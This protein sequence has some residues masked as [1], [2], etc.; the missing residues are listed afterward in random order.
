MQPPAI[1]HQTW[2]ERALA[3]GASG[4]GAI[5]Q[6]IDSWKNAVTGMGTR[7]DKTTASQLFPDRVLSPMELE[8]LFHN[9]DIAARIVSAVVNEAFREPWQIVSKTSDED[10]AEIQR[11]Q[12]TDLAADFKAHGVAKKM[13]EAA[14]W[15]RLYGLGACLIGV[16]EEPRWNPRTGRMEAIP[17]WEP[18]DWQRVRALDYVTVLDRRDMIPWRW[19]TDFQ[20][21][22]F[23]DVALYQ[24]QPAGVFMG[25]SYG[26]S[27]NEMSLVHESRLIRFGG[28]LTSKRERLRNQGADFSILQKVFRA[29][30]L[31]NTNWQA[32]SALMADASQGVF[33]ITGLVD[34]IAQQPDEMKARMEFVDFMRSTMQAIVLDKDGEDFTR[35]A[36]PFTDLPE[37]LQ[38]TW[39]RLACAVPMPLTIL[40]GQSKTGLN[41]DDSDMRAWY[42]QVGQWQRD[43]QVPAAER[44]LQIAAAA[45]G[46]SSVDDW[47]INPGALWQMTA[48]QKADYALKI[49]QRD[50]LYIDDGVWMADEV[51]LARA[52]DPTGMKTEIDLDV[53]KRIL[54]FRLELEEA[55]AKNPPPAPVRT[56]VPGKGAAVQVPAKPAEKQ[57][58]G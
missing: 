22:R 55:N 53:R 47:T 50:H 16:Q 5:R 40:M 39:S 30:Q 6:R 8:I 23:G 52:A 58:A 1:P 11:S 32:A 44:M 4:V 46:F 36:T 7:R 18:L 41:S 28:A 26:A 57:I 54:K 15:G 3:A 31:T 13:R 35:V 25:A 19:Y 34:M 43:E 45:R 20:A 56:A 12:A 37:M 42:D 24:V 51:A 27:T 17:P 49:A 21:P 33:K 10:T 9:D 2:T 38:Q 14:T 29:L 48:A